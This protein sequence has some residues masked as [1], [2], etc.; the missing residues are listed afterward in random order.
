MHK[1]WDGTEWSSAKAL[2][3]WNGTQWKAGLKFKV[4]T[5]TSWLPGSVSDKDD[6]QIIKW[7]VDAPTP[8]PP[9]PPVTHPVPDLDLKTLLEVDALLSPLAFD[10]T[11][12]DYEVTSDNTKDDKVVIDSQNPPAGQLLA[13]GSTVTIKLYNFVQPTTTV[14]NLDNLLISA[15]NTAI[16]NA[17]L[18]VS[19][20]IG[21]D[22]TYDTNLIGR[23][24]NGSQYPSAGS[25]VDTGT[26]VTYDKWVQ[27]AFA[28]VP[29]IVGLLDSQVFSTLDAANLN[30]GTRTVVAT[31]VAANDE[32]VKSQY[33]AQGTQVQQDSNVNYEVWDY[34]LRVVPNLNGLTQEQASNAITNAGL[35]VGTISNQETTVVADEGKV[36]SNSQSHP[37]GSEVNAGTSINFTVWVPNTT[38][39]VP[40]VVNLVGL[41]TIQNTITAA[42]LNTSLRNI[43]Y[44]RDSNLFNKCYAQNPPAGNV[45]NINSTVYVDLYLQEPVYTVPSIIGLTPSTGAI[46]SNFTWGSNSLASTSTESTSSFGK[47]ATQSPIAGT[48][49]YAGSINYGIYVDGRPTVPN[50]V[51]QTEATAKTNINNVGLNW[52]VTYQNQTFNGQATAGTVASQGTPAGTRLASG[53]TVS[54][55][56]WNAYTAQP[57]TRTGVVYVG[58]NAFSGWD[59]NGVF[60]SWTQGDLDWKNQASWRNVELSTGTGN[61]R[62]TSTW[63]R[64]QAWVGRFDATNGKQAYMAQFDKGAVDSRIKA[65]ITG[66]ATYTVGNIDIVFQVNST[67]GG[68]SKDWYFHYWN[69]TT[70]PTTA[71][72]NQTNWYVDTQL[73]STNINNGDVMS[74]TINATLKSEVGH[75][76]NGTG[77]SKPFIIGGGYG[78]TSSANYGSIDW[79]YMRIPITWT[80][81]V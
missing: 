21:T 4:R 28:T 25:T 5:S 26:E 17:N 63:Q 53:S 14:P 47:V 59:K 76:V 57:V 61:S 34:S 55:V 27:K 24:I 81:Y 60:T 8:P 40:N 43:T 20:N 3:V 41:S 16:T 7:S 74:P 39:T 11:V 77:M 64:M 70:F 51:G 79:C 9:P 68:A 44:T 29:N 62:A 31:S 1:V 6:S 42:E 23:V 78:N 72:E 13:E 35:Y 15:A 37:A 2:K 49:T 36:K 46:N 38:T 10:Y 71:R 54:I 65:S 12:T 52:S 50:V 58:D 19:T 30:I 45:V 56:V 69:S 32:K 48:S 67:S 22:E 18:V 73:I 33:P 66:G 80:E 75:A